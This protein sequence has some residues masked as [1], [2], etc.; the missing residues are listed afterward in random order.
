[1]RSSVESCS[2]VRSWFSRAARSR[3][4]RVAGGGRAAGSLDCSLSD[5]AALLRL[6]LREL[7]RARKAAAQLRGA[8]VGGRRVIERAFHVD[9]RQEHG[10]RC[11]SNVEI[12]LNER[13]RLQ[14][15][16][17]L[18]GQLEHVE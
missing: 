3:S 7:R 5:I 18:R 11:G 13:A 16:A 1:M 6:E 10:R 14:V 2:T 8:P 4:P 9:A 15:V 17:A 12:A